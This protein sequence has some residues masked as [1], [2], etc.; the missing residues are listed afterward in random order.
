MNLPE[1][2]RWIEGFDHFGHSDKIRVFAWY[3]H[4]YANSERI[5]TKDLGECFDEAHLHRP[6]N[7]SQLVNQLVGRD[8]MRLPSN[9]KACSAQ[10]PRNASARRLTF[11]TPGF[12]QTSEN[13][14]PPWRARHSS[15]RTRTRN[16]EASSR[17]MKSPAR[18]PKVIHRLKV[19][20]VD[21]QERESAAVARPHL[22]FDKVDSVAAVEDGRRADGFIDRL[23]CAEDAR[24][25]SSSRFR[26]PAAPSHRL[27]PALR[28]PEG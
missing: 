20:D 1:F 28:A 23:H 15:R 5:S 12:G 2:L 19:V 8:L 17:K 18:C 10:I 24:S 13:S 9:V 21:E 22:A 4:S 27:H 14:S 3:L 16:S 25:R 11:V 7:L 6:A 26:M